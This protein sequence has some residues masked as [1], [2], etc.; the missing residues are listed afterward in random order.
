MENNNEFKNINDIENLDELGLEYDDTFEFGTGGNEMIENE[1]KYLF[2]NHR[3]WL[4]KAGGQKLSV[5]SMNFSNKKFVDENLQ[6]ATFENCDM[7]YTN[8]QNI[9]FS[10]AV[11]SKCNLEG[12]SFDNCRFHEAKFV[13]CKFNKSVIVNNVGLRLE[14]KSS[15]FQ[16]VTFVSNQ[17]EAISFET[18]IVKKTSLLSNFMRKSFIYDS[19]FYDTKFSDSDL[20][21]SNINTCEFTECE[22]NG[23]NFDSSIIKNNIMIKNKIISTIFT[24]ISGI[25]VYSIQVPIRDKSTLI[26]NIPEWDLWLYENISGSVVDLYK[27]WKSIYYLSDDK[28]KLEDIVYLISNMKN[29]GNQNTKMEKDREFNWY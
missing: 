6:K 24:N 1:Y 2:D 25:E 5:N 13:D 17:F 22:F 27:Y 19:E 4:N 7:S 8:F 28:D 26:Q 14:I 21:E 10:E 23:I 16:N 29:K 11:F 20:T 18:C 3:K 12:T 15:E 9:D